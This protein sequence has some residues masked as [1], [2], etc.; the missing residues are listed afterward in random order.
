MYHGENLL[1]S[2]FKEQSKIIEMISLM[3]MPLQETLLEL[4]QTIDMVMPSVC[5]SI[6]IFDENTETLGQ[7]IGPK[8]PKGYL[9]EIEGLKIGSKAGLVGLLPS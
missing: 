4:T 1:G 2:I 5:S 3:N 9:Q 6:L 7:G 8:L